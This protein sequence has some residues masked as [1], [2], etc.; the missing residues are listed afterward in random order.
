MSV[1]FHANFGL[2]RANMSGVLKR[3]LENP[4]F[5]D[6]DLAKSFGYGAPFASRTRSWLNKT[7]I[8]ELGLPVELTNKGKIVWEKDPD[9]KL[10]ITQW[11]MHWEL[12]Q[13]PNRA[14]T[15]HYFYH[16]FLP[17]HKKFTREELVGWLTM[18]LSSHSEEHF[19]PGSPMNKI[20]AHKIIECYT[21]DSALGNLKILEKLEKGYLKG[22]P[23][24]VEGPWEIL[25]QLES[26][27]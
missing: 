24:I 5:K 11:F 4:N 6:I 21:N 18:K 16:E 8:I 26:I 23:P 25:E 19:G 7:G 2:N 14:E 20:I 1:Y 3:A 17:I 9:F 13:D 27:Y 12:T 15:W 10:L 22:V